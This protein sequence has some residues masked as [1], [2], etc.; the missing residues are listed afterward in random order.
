MPTIQIKCAG[1]I[2]LALDELNVLQGDLKELDEPEYQ[3]LRTEIIETGFAFAPHAWKDPDGKWWLVDGTQRTRTLLRM[4]EEDGYFVPPL[5]V[6]PVEA[7]DLKEAHRRIM[8]GTSAYGRMTERGLAAFAVKAGITFEGLGNFRFPEVNLAA[9]HSR[10]SPGAA[11]VADAEEDVVETADFPVLPTGDRQP[12]QQM[13]FTL[14]DTQVEVVKRA[15][16]TARGM[17]PFNGATNE[18]GNGN[19]LARACE[20][21]LREHGVS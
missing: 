4:R 10:L 3:K 20:Y 15:L 9:V 1:A 6:V 7:V 19:A 17:G 13:T 18:N 12:Y 8:Q 2:R 21:F 14:H 5:P 11:G 16:Q